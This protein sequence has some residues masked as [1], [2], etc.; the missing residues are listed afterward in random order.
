MSMPLPNSVVALL[1]MIG[2]LSACGGGAGGE[3]PADETGPEPAPADETISRAPLEGHQVRFDQTQWPIPHVQPSSAFGPRQKAADG[4]RY[5][6]HRGIDLAADTGTPVSAI[7]DG[8][9]YQAYRAEDPAN[10]YPDGGNVV[11]LRHPLDQEFPLHGQAHQE[12][13]SLY[14]HLD[15]VDVAAVPPGGPYPAVAA[16]TILGSVGQSGSASIPH[17]HFETRVGTPC[18][19]EFQRANPDTHCSR[20]FHGGPADPHVNPLMFLD[21]DDSNRLELSVLGSS[22]LRI[23]VRLPGLEADFNQIRVSFRG[24]EKT[25]DF[26]TRAGIDPHNLDNPEYAGISVQPA[27]FSASSANYDIVFEFADFHGFDAIEARDHWGDGLM[28]TQER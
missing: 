13:Y 21:Y 28:L 6:F 26:N 7:A 19:R 17:L 24:V 4:F 22:P 9:I 3:T 11:V 2:M 18:S 23:R 10:P 8:V 14:M 27:R 20:Y 25:V 1:L 12:Y 5:D 16:G 15:R